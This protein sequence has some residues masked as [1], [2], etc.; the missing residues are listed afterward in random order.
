MSERGL[1][2]RFPRAFT[3]AVKECAWAARRTM[4][5]SIMLSWLQMAKR[6]HGHD[7]YLRPLIDEAEKAMKDK[8]L[9]PPARRP[10]EMDDE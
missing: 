6:V 1:T 4:T 5:A 8:G 7:P 10:E 2:L 3:V 9:R